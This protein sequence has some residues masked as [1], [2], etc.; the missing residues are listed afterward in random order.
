MLCS[1][2]ESDNAALQVERCKLRD[3][4]GT[5]ETFLTQNAVEAAK[6]EEKET[7]KRDIEKSLIKSK[8][9][10]RA[11]KERGFMLRS[12]REW[13]SLWAVILPLAFFPLS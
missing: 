6:M 11:A 5:Y 8:S 7:K 12:S 10:V 9:K 4:G 13:S 3:F 1:E 2:K